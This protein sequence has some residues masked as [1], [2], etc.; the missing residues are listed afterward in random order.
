MSNSQEAA[1]ANTAL[2]RLPPEDF[3]STEMV[4]AI[5]DQS[6]G[7]CY[8]SFP[9]TYSRQHGRIYVASRA[10]LF[11]SN[12]FGFERRLSMSLSEITEIKTY[13]STSI[14]ISMMDG[15]DFVFK[16]LSGRERVVAMVR[17]LLYNVMP[18]ESPTLQLEL[19]PSASHESL[20]LAL[21]SRPR[22]PR[23]RAQS[24]P[25]EV[26]PEIIFES[27]RS[28]R[29]QVERM[30]GDE[31]TRKT[32]NGEMS[33]ATSTCTENLMEEW[34]KE[35]QK[36]HSMY[37]ERAIDNVIL[38]CSLGDFFDL[39]LAD[40]APH[41]MI[42]YQE[43]KIGDTQVK[44]TKWILDDND[45][46]TRTI[47]FCHPI[48]NSFGI[49]PSSTMA[50]RE[51]TLNRYGDFGI[52]LATTTNVSG[53]PAA[54]AFHVADYW[55]VEEISSHQICFTALHKIVFTKRTV[56]KRVIETTTKGEIESWYRGYLAMLVDRVQGQSNTRSV[57]A[58]QNL[59]DTPTV[60]RSFSV[61]PLT[62]VVVALLALL[63]HNLMLNSLVRQL[64]VDVKSV[65]QQQIISLQLLQE[66][67][68]RLNP[69]D[70]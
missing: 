37:K 40:E 5:F 70:H 35:K 18:R 50:T 36:Q 51:Q 33:F 43:Q 47:S 32:S 25:T 12:I 30:R 3:A 2:P 54:D 11:F 26:H 52:C 24:C 61:W 22:S 62:A 41:S 57:T 17:T 55:L 31:P 7:N 38:N 49:G 42:Q 27:T 14:W 69:A 58:L 46:M 48:A 8:G 1:T 66:V 28:D 68:A 56:F 16:S 45:C 23:V 9:C 39:F 67:I 4:H 15:E 44:A 19:E 29:A 6:V 65:Q 34:K 59:V 10:V 60:R 53:V 63:I 21:P 20:D 13:R 64:Q